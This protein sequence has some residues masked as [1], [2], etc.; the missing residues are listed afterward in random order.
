MGKRLREITQ[1]PSDVHNVDDGGRGVVGLY[2]PSGAAWQDD[3]CV[4]PAWQ[5]LPVS[6]GV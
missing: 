4:D 3:M 5:E 2:V 1:E 6:T